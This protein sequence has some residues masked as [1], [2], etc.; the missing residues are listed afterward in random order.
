MIIRCADI[1]LSDL[2]FNVL[3]IKRAYDPNKGKWAL[4]GGKLE[5]AENPADGCLREL[6]EETGIE[7][8]KKQIW[9]SEVLEDPFPDKVHQ[10]YI[11]NAILS[12]IPNVE[13]SHES[14]AYSLVNKTNFYHYYNNTVDFIKPTIRKIMGV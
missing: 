3:M 8:F 14:T 11:Y 7:L 9:I 12:S 1:L 6:K 5:R 4:P 2:N 10:V 13:L